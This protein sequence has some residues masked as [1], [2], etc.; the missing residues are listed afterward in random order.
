MNSFLPSSHLGNWEYPLPSITS[1]TLCKYHR[2]MVMKRLL[3]LLTVPILIKVSLAWQMTLCSN[4]LIMLIITYA[5]LWLL[6]IITFACRWLAVSGCWVFRYSTL[7]T[8]TMQ[9][10]EM[11]DTAA[12][13]TI[14]R[15]V[16]KISLNCNWMEHVQIQLT[17]VIP[18]L[19]YMSGN[20]CT[21]VHA[22]I[23]RKIKL[24]LLVLLWSI[25]YFTYR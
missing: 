1:H 6:L 18:T 11:A 9:K 4:S 2:L 15:S 7:R 23:P 14:Q 25:L 21:I 20:V 3:V 22:L 19:C 16:G 17:A 13:I 24:I 12:V 5:K 8:Y 10:L